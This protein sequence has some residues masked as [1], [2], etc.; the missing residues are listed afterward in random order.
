M[1]TSGVFDFLRVIFAYAVYPAVIFAV[2]GVI[3]WRMLTLLTEHK[4]DTLMQWRLAVAGLLPVTVLTFVVVREL[5]EAEMWLPQ[6][7]QWLYQLTAGTL[8]A[9]A[10][11]EAS[12]RITGKRQALPFM[13]YLAS[14][15][16]GLL[17]VLMEGALARFQPAVF[18]AVLIGGLHFIFR[19][20]EEDE[21]EADEPKA[22]RVQLD[23]AR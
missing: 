15:G 11:L 7:D 2:F 20:T 1:G 14:L 18:A 4:Y 16:T 13:L 10:A 23:V 17:Y 5:P 19:E 9:V 8:L 22:E 6:A 12:L 21:W 3:G